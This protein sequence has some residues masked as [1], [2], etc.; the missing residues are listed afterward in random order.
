M[1]QNMDNEVL[2]QYGG[3]IEN[4]LNN[5]LRSHENSDDEI[6]TFQH[7]Q[8]YDWDGLQDI[9]LDKNDSFTVL[10]LNCQSI[11]AKLTRY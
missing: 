11:H 7:S 10:S 5:L 8:Y 4:N 1:S 9:L 2:K 6:S 3:E